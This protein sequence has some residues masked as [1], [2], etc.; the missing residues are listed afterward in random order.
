MT[1]SNPTPVAAATLASDE[2]IG[3]LAEKEKE[4]KKRCQSSCRVAAPRD[5]ENGLRGCYPGGDAS[6]D[7]V[8]FSLVP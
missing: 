6:P 4:T 7:K 5:H 1:H 2:V 8:G 3:R